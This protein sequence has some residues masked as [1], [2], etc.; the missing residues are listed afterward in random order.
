MNRKANKRHPWTQR[1]LD[2]L[3][4]HYADTPMDVLM[5][6]TG[7][8]KKSIWRLA[9]A[10]GLHKSRE[11]LQ[12]CGRRSSQHPAS[13]AHRFQKG[14]KPWNKGLEEWQIRSQD[15]IERCRKTQFKPGN[16][17]HNT[18]PVGYERVNEEGYILIKVEEGRKMVL[19]HRWVW[20]QA[21]GKIPAGYN[22]MFRDG[23]RQ[24]CSLDNLELVS[25]SEAA[26]RQ[27]LAETPEQRRNRMEKCLATRS[28]TIRLDKARIHF[29][30]EPKTKLVKRW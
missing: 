28:K 2:Y 26:R 4:Q 10:M 25:R 3:R 17:P 6:H 23:N 24:N 5:K 11:F 9:S 1:Q 27:V 15:A 12:E 18:K 7:H 8:P 19:K 13:I 30:L 29:G 14:I 21:Y 16:S 22:V 20:K